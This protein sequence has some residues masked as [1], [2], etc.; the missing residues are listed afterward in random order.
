MHIINQLGG[1]AAQLIDYFPSAYIDQAR[2]DRKFD[3]LSS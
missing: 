3:Q 1:N 2:P